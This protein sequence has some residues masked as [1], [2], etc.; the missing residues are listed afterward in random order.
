MSRL[1]GRG[2][3]GRC[4]DLGRRAKIEVNRENGRV[5]FFGSEASV[6]L[7][8]LVD[9]VVVDAVSVGRRVAVHGRGRA[10]GVPQVACAPVVPHSH[11]GDRGLRPRAMLRR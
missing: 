5:H 3:R 2:V 9:G 11:H 1:L 8:Y 7:A 10:V 6:Y 4:R